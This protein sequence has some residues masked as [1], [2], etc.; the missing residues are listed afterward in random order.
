MANTKVVLMIS[1]IL[2][3]LILFNG[4]FSVHGRAL[5]SENKEHKKI[6][7]SNVLWHRH[8]LGN[9]GTELN[10]QNE[11]EVEKWVDDFR[12]TEPGHSPG[13]GHSSPHT[14]ASDVAPRP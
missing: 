11:R 6:Y 13:V 7:K 8:M 2:L 1:S 3:A 10:S 14:I 12:P 4:I 5:R 9:V